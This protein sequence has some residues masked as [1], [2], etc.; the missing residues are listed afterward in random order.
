[1]DLTEDDFEDLSKYLFGSTHMLAVMLEVS[2]SSDGYF[3]GPQVSAAT[4]LPASTVH[5]LVTRLKRARLVRRTGSTTSERVAIYERR[6]HPYW[7]VA[8]FIERE[9]QVG[10]PGGRDARWVREQLSV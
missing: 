6:A 10:A 4:G 2:R 8:R 1:M 9:S 3:T 5:A 7:D